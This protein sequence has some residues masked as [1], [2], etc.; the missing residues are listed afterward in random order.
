MTK[1]YLTRDAFDEES[2]EFER[3][4]REYATLDDVLK[5]VENVMNAPRKNGWLKVL[6]HVI[7]DGNDTLTFVIDQEMSAHMKKKL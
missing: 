1:Y 4:T 7:D 3:K 2:E 5:I 6:S